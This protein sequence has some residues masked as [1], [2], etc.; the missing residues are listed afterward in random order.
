MSF[1]VADNPLYSAAS[2]AA[3]ISQVPTSPRGT[4]IVARAPPPPPPG[5]GASAEPRARGGQVRRHGVPERRLLGDLGVEGG[6][7]LDP[8]PHRLGVPGRLA[9][10]VLRARRVLLVLLRGELLGRLPH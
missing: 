5:G 3:M 7:L 9:C 2:V 8:S 1:A 6:Q 10:C 4:L